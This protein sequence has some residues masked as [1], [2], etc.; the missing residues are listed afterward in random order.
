MTV[1][2]QLLVPSSTAMLANGLILNPVDV[3]HRAVVLRG[4][5]GCV[6]GLQRLLRRPGST[7]R[8]P[9]RFPRPH[10]ALKIPFCVYSDWRGALNPALE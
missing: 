8:C 5:A 9:T 7:Q 3:G 6:Q 4:I 2:R 1:V 10:P